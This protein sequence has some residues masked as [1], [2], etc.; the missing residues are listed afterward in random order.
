M[1]HFVTVQLSTESQA[2]SLYNWLLRNKV[3]TD[4]R[5]KRLRFGFT[6]YLKLTEVKNLKNLLSTLNLR[7]ID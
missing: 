1:G 5:G 6:P 7:E 3:M 4:F 2:Q